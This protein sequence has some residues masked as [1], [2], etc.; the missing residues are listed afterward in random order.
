MTIS[1]IRELFH[2]DRNQLKMETE[3]VNAKALEELKNKLLEKNVGSYTVTI[4]D[5]LIDFKKSPY[6][7]REEDILYLLTK[8]L[9]DEFINLIYASETQGSNNEETLTKILN[10]S[11]HD[12]TIIK[13]REKISMT[14]INDVK[15]L[16][17]NSFDKNL[18]D[19]E[20][21]IVKLF[22]DTINDKI[23]ELSRIQ[24]EYSSNRGN[25]RY[26]GENTVEETINI[27]KPITRIKGASEFF[28]SVSENKTLIESNMDKI[29]SII[30]FFKGPQKRQFDDAKHSVIIYEDN[31]QF[32]GND[33]S[34]I[35]AVKAITDILTMEEPFSYIHELPHL[36]ENLN[37][38]LAEM[39]D[40]RSIPVV[41]Q[42]KNVIEFI[43]N[44]IERTNVDSAIGERYI[45]D[46]RKTIDEIDRNNQLKDILASE[47]FIK[48]RKEEFSLSLE[49]E[50]Q[51]LEN[52]NNEQA[53]E[54][55]NEPKIIR[56]RINADSLFNKTYEIDSEE[57]IDKLLKEIRE[58]LINELNNNKNLTVR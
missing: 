31:K 25:Y 13:L 15:K 2:Q 20:D 26:P 58:K 56:K 10:R 12:K 11:Y 51:R 4:N 53:Q 28:D 55:I 50:L 5:I 9:K 43:N 57:D 35:S 1:D 24:G 34:L 46:L 42:A 21:D 3:F 36:R 23:N 17:L 52:I 7:Y 27:L 47:T 40:K 45:N 6:G 33:E 18:P 32:A 22:T 54:S 38:I 48:Q 49:K 29:K 8:L 41:E 16:A 39:Y 30:D 37:N 44:E 19:A 14:L